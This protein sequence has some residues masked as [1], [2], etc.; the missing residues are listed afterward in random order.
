MGIVNQT[1]R[2]TDRPR[3]T[4]VAD[5]VLVPV[6]PKVN[7]HKRIYYYRIVFYSCNYYYRIWLL[8]YL[9]LLY[10]VLLFYLLLYCIVFCY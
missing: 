1:S 4:K 8:L 9:L 6:S 5:E 10:F 2:P 7:M 3:T